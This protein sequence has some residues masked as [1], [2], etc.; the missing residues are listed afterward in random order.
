MALHALFSMF[1]SAEKSIKIAV[2]KGRKD[3]ASTDIYQRWCMPTYKYWF[4]YSDILYRF[5]M[6]VT[7]Y[8]ICLIT[9]PL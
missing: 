5:S 9:K 8:Y 1:P 6:G 2:Q 4:S 7:G 3:Y